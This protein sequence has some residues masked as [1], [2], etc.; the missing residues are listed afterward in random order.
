MS[1]GQTPFVPMVMVLS[2]G[3]ITMVLKDPYYQVHDHPT[4]N[5]K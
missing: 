2:I 3:V 5:P 4:V 1:H